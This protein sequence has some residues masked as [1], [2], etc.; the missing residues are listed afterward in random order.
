MAMCVCVCLYNIID[1][2]SHHIPESFLFWFRFGYPHIYTKTFFFFL[3]SQIKCS[4][5]RVSVVAM[6]WCEH[7]SVDGD[8]LQ[9]FVEANIKREKKKVNR[10]FQMNGRFPIPHK[11]GLAA[12]VAAAVVWVC[13]YSTHQRWHRQP[14]LLHRKIKCTN[15]KA[16]SLSVQSKAIIWIENRFHAVKSILHFKTR[17]KKNQ[18]NT[19][20]MKAFHKMSLHFQHIFFLCRFYF[21]LQL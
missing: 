11:I 16:Y 21:D 10:S 15:N 4:T 9:L 7:F 6:N 20:E 17:K 18:P 2:I 14:L 5:M 1:T 3:K 12:A 13:V 8:K 19:H